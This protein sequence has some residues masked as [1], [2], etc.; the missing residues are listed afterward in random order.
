M[1]ITSAAGSSTASDSGGDTSALAAIDPSQQQNVYND[2]I[3]V[4]QLW[5]SSARLQ[6]RGVS[7]AVVDSGVFKTKDLGKRVRVNVN[8][9][10][11]FHN[12]AA[13]TGT[14]RSSPVS[15]PVTAT[16]RM[17]SISAWRHGPT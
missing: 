13:A 9:N 14:A 6:G 4:T 2:A 8:F 17:V 15:S 7:V 12:G 5:N 1:R 3:R 10:L 11:G 16:S